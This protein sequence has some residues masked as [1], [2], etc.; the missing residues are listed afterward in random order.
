M[1]R[2]AE[3]HQRGANAEFIL[4]IK[5]QAIERQRFRRMKGEVLS[6]PVHLIVRKVREKRILHPGSCRCSRSSTL[7]SSRRKFTAHLEV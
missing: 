2:S 7:I 5:T 6:D 4:K 3:R 1:A